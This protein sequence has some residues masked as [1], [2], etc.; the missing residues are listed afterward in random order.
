MAAVPSVPPHAEPDEHRVVLHGVTWEQYLRISE[1]FDDRP[2]LRLT[3]LE[4]ALE[5]MTTGGTHEEL[6]KRIARLIETWSEVRGVDLRGFGSTTLRK[7]AEQRGLEPDECY[8]LGERP[9]V[10]EPQVIDRPDL[11]I[12]IVISTPLV[13]KL[14]VY[15]GLGVPEVWTFRNGVFL[16][17]VLEGQR[18]REAARSQLLPDL[19]L[20]LI[21]ELTHEPKQIDAVRAVRARLGEGPSAR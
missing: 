11:A 10:A 15:A 12:E 2:A 17:H 4:G 21:A 13:D 1:L 7:S 19:D 3:Y 5:I 20:P 18:Y 9:R 16:V 8:C 6:K 14:R